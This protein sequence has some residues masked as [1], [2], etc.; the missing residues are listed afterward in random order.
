MKK[1][2]ISGALA[3]LVSFMLIG[4]GANANTGMQNK[5][6][7]KLKNCSFNISIKRIRREDSW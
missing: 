5:T 4:C 7:D 1:K 6:E 3:V 2:I